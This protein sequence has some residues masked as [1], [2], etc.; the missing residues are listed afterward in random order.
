[1]K[2]FLSILCILSL[3]LGLLTGISFARPGG[4][5]DDDDGG[6]SN[7]GDSNGVLEIVVPSGVSITMRNAWAGTGSTVSASSTSTSGGWKT[8]TYRGLATGSY[9]FTTSGSGYN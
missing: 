9:S 8:Y 3:L 7:T 1:M 4:N 2:R 5:D 6:G